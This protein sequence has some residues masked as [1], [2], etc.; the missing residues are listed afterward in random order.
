MYY[1]NLILTLVVVGEPSHIGTRNEDLLESSPSLTY[2]STPALWLPSTGVLIALLP[3]LFLTIV[4]QDVRTALF[5]M[6]EIQEE[7]A[8]IQLSYDDARMR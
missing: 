2:Q 5:R 3:S 7:L 1:L 4:S 8:A 6:K